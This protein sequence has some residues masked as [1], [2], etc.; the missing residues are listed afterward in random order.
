MHPNSLKSRK[1]LKTAKRKK[2]REKKKKQE[3]SRK[4]TDTDSRISG[5]RYSSPCYPK[6][7][8][9]VLSVYVCLCKRWVLYYNQLRSVSA[10][11]F[12]WCLHLVGFIN[13]SG[14]IISPLAVLFNS[15]GILLKSACKK[16]AQLVCEH[17]LRKVE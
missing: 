14:H 17:S 13:L 8:T 5:R 2:R 11:L 4:K 1:K 7:N 15:L 16:A 10:R 9:S 12:M 3:R 6:S